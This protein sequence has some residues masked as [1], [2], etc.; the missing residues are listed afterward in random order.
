MR[1]LKGEVVQ[2][3]VENVYTEETQAEEAL[4]RSEEQA[5]HLLEF[6]NKVID[7]AN[8]WIDLLD[9]EGNVTLW[10]R[11]AELISGYSREEV[12]GHRKIWEWLYP[13][14][15]YRAKIFAQ[16]KRTI[17]KGERLENY[18]TIIRLSLIHI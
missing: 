3:S 18:H 17:E 6:H 7:T 8:V 10:N 11:A 9:K 4:R 13:E 12:V 16:A 5:R 1:L 15:E 14:P 2:S